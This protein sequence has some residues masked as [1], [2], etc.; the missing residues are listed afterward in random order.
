MDNI[1][2]PTLLE[3]IEKMKIEK[4]S[5]EYCLYI[6]KGEIS[7]QDFK[8]HQNNVKATKYFSDVSEDI[9]TKIINYDKYKQEIDEYFNLEFLPKLLYINDFEILASLPV[10]DFS[11]L[12]E[13]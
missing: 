8:K 5:K 11:I 2:E 10:F 13:Q 4:N 3:V 9:P 7:K 6:V 1:K 12:E